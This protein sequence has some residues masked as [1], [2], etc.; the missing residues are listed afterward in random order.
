[1]ETLWPALRELLILCLASSAAEALLGD[2]SD[3]VR[4]ICG[5]SAALCVSRAIAGLTA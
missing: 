1:M 3:G 4:A 5:L 2:R